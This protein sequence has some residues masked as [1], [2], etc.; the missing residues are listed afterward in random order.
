METITKE[1]NLVSLFGGKKV[2]HG[3][4][5]SSYLGETTLITDDN[6]T[7]GF[8]LHK[9]IESSSI[10]DFLIYDFDT[11]QTIDKFKIFIED[12]KGQSVYFCLEDAKGKVVYLQEDALVP[13]DNQIYS[14]PQRVTNVKKAYIWNSNSKGS[15]YKV[16]EWD[17]Y[18]DEALDK[19]N[20]A[21]LKITLVNEVIKEYDLSAQELETFIDWYDTRTKGI[22]LERYS[23][24]KYWNM[25]PFAKR[26]EYIIYNKIIMF[27]VDEYF[28]KENLNTN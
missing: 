4:N 27:E 7:T 11:P 25:G 1:E 21:I 10:S 6:P 19:P 15:D 23:F 8:L 17:L 24:K 22:G 13:G 18:R 14:L 20:R 9:E 12:Y 28:D 5:K 16:L 26:T 2:K 3:N